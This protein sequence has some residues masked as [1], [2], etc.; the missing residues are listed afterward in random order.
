[1]LFREQSDSGTL[2]DTLEVSMSE[3]ITVPIF[4]PG[5]SGVGLGALTGS[6]TREDLG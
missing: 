6:A 2:V 5:R 3:E 1:M 4:L